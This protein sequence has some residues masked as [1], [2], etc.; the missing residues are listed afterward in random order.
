MP[1]PLRNSTF[2][3]ALARAGLLL[4]ALCAPAAASP[5][6][7]YYISVPAFGQIWRLDAQTGDL[8]P[9]ASGLGI[10][11]YGTWAPDGF[12]YVPDRALGAVFR[13]SDAGQVTPFSAG[14]LLESVVTVVVA[15]DGGLIASDIFQQNIVRLLP[16]GSQLLLA[17]VASSG[18]LLDYPGGLGYGPD[19]TLYVANNLG[20]TIASVDDRTGATSLV[21]DG[22]GL[23][24]APG[25]LAVD[26]AQNL[27]V[28]NYGDGNIVRL[29][30]DDGDAEVFCDDP[31][32]LHPN[33]VRLAPGG[34]LHVTM[35]FRLAHIDALGQLSV[36]KEE[37]GF[38]AWDGVASKAYNAP[39][40]GSFTR[41]GSG[42]AGSGG[43]VP[44][45]RGLFAP[46]PGAQAGL[47]LDRL[48][49]GTS[50]VLAWG[51]APAAAPF[52]QGTL[53]VS[54]GPPGGL[55]PL[56]F[57]G[58]LPGSGALRLA[59]TLPDDPA[60]AGLALH[61]QALA[62]DPG[63]PAGVSLSNGLLESIGS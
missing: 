23:L 54:L 2:G 18:G 24:T 58:D 19:G 4:G 6:D 33:D 45:L 3:A 41:Y 47:E 42:L 25:G 27:Y 59:F 51:L 29:R 48:L 37:P 32:L 5:D 53:H 8:S 22:G 50:G 52:K 44:R 46:C 40:A 61:L 20:G 14:G 30:L 7:D 57:P 38:G 63:A 11:F 1:R 34:G 36:V 55:I 15:P 39:C 43:H 28:A 26:N 60:L 35:D 56:F 16:D 13:I 49:G 17:D 9:F 21:S 10:P 31:L 62:L 12:L